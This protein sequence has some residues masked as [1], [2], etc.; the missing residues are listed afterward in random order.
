[1]KRKT[2]SAR[3]RMLANLAMDRWVLNL[4]ANRARKWCPRDAARAEGR[5]EG[6]ASNI[7]RCKV[8]RA[9]GKAEGW[10]EG[11]EAIRDYVDRHFDPGGGICEVLDAHIANE[12][13]RA[14]CRERVCLLV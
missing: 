8:A 9:E 14:S 2:P 1:M 5:M 7:E 11:A 13:G 10:R 6:F 3:K 12:I 4:I